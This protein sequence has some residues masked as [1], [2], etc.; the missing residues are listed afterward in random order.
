MFLNPNT[1]LGNAVEIAGD[2]IT[3]D[4]MVAA[5]RKVYGKTPMSINEQFIA[6]RK[7]G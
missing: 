3:F 5:Y 7:A 6:K 4:K 1:Y 2:A